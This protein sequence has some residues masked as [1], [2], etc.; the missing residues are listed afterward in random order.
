MKYVTLRGKLTDRPFNSVAGIVKE[1]FVSIFP[2]NF[3][4]TLYETYITD[5]IWQLA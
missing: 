4:S 5:I 1:P 3:I 2:I